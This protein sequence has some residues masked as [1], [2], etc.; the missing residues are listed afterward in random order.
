[1][2]Q[3]YMYL[4]DPRGKWV[5][6]SD[7]DPEDDEIEFE[8]KS[9]GVHQASTEIFMKHLKHMEGELYKYTDIMG[10]LGVDTTHLEGLVRTILDNAKNF[11]NMSVEKA[12]SAYEL[13]EDG[14]DPIDVLEDNHQAIVNLWEEARKIGMQLDNYD[15][16]KI[17]LK[18]IRY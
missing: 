1:M 8:M 11:Y 12:L 10:R 6:K 16:N 18:D 13:D 3:N 14:I 2:T 4:N 15:F 17:T 5:F 7:E 9:L